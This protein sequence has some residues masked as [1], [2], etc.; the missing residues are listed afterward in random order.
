MEQEFNA[1]N[2]RESKFQIAR[3]EREAREKGG[4]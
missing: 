3:A 4:S 1:Q 2:R